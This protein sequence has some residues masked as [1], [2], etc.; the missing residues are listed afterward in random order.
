[1]QKKK[2]VAKG[3]KLTITLS[4]RDMATL[5]QLAKSK[6]VTKA[7]AAKRILRDSLVEFKKNLPTKAPQNQLGLFDSVQIDIFNHTMKTEN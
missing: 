7:I 1:M 5:Q 6:K 2:K 4:E 3:K